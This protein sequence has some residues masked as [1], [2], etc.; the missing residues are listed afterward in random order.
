MTGVLGKATLRELQIGLAGSIVLPEE[1]NYESARRVWNRAIDRR[2]A[3]IVRAASTED[4]ARAVRFARSEG[5][6]IAVRGGGHSVAGFSTGDDAIVIDLAQ[7]SD[8]R[9]DVESRRAFARGGS[10][11]R[12]FDAATQ[13]HG[14]ASTGGQI[15]STGVGGLTLGGGIGHLVRKCGLACDNLTA[16]ELVTPD[17]SVIRATESE[18]SELLWALRG[19]GGNFGVV[20]TFEFDLHPVGPT[21]LGGVVFYPGDQTIDVVSGWR[22]LL[23]QAPDELSTTVAL[24]T[25]PPA[26]FIPPAWHGKK[27]VGVIACW[28]GDP[29]EGEDVVKP[30]RAL[31]TPITDQLA[32]IAYVDLQ[33]LVDPLWEA[34]AANYFTSAFL[35]RLPDEAVETLSDYHQRSASGPAQTELHVHHIGGAMTRIPAARTA[36]AHRS[37]SFM[38]NCLARTAELAELSEHVVWARSAQVAVA[39]HGEGGMYVN[40]AGEGGDENLRASYPTAVLSRLKAVKDQYDPF[41]AFRFNLNIPPSE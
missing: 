38:V 6:P 8:V 15:S 21:V 30:F 40:F 22:D 19:G 35:H 9:V 12:I 18:N 31:G 14:L 32:P 1:P 36:F 34:G 41:N 20:T 17:G 27:V 3:L 28:A 24:T 4:V 11:W 26:P 13:R 5:R 10:T 16:V 25:A 7:L 33:Q 29:V 39:K 37:S 23:D 2:P